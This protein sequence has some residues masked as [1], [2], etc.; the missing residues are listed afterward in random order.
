MQNNIQYPWFKAANN[1]RDI[2]KNFSKLVA[3]N[4]MTMGDE[5]YKLEKKLE[6]KLNVKHV[7][8]STSGTSALTMAT[9]ALNVNHNTKVITTNLTWIAT[10]N[11]ALFVN[12]NIKVIDTYTKN[13]CINFEKLIKEIKVFKPDILYLVHLNG[14]IFYNEE[15]DRLKRSM[16]FLIIEDAAQSFLAKQKNLYCGTKYEIGCFSLGITKL[17][18]MIYGG[19]CTTNSTKL[20]NKLIAIRNNGVNAEPENSKMEI[21]KINGFNFK[22]SNLHATIGLINLKNSRQSLSRIISIYKL[23]KTKLLNHKRITMVENY[24]RN[25][26]PLYI[27]IYTDNKKEFI[28]FCNQKGIGLHF[29]LRTLNETKLILSKKK[30][31]NSN[32]FSKNLIRLPCGPGYSINEINKIINIL[33]K[34]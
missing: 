33:N 28:N 14:D 30:F 32:F 19:F 24:N 34:Y 16:G 6:K 12:A 10:I 11:P 2:L 13:Q 27:L 21:A 9:S 15:L 3:K 8:L 4:K 26:I 25:A 29:A 1:N 31:P 23:Y 7:V 17:I 5:V 20:Y 22:P 18:N